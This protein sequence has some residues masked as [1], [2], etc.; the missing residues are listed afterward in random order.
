MLRT[1]C[2]RSDVER[3]TLD[4]DDLRDEFHLDIFEEVRLEGVSGTATLNA[5]Q[6]QEILDRMHERD[7]DGLAVSAL[8]R[9]FRMGDRYGN[10]E[11]LDPFQKN[12]KTIWSAREGV[13]EPWTD[14]GFD[15]CMNAAARS[16][17]ERR[18]IRRRTMNGKLKT[19]RRQQAMCGLCPPYG[20]RYDRRGPKNGAWIIHEEEA[21]IV[22]IIFRM[23][24]KGDSGYSIA[25]WLNAQGYKT[26]R[27]G[28]WAA[29]VVRKVLRKRAYIG[30]ARFRHNIE[31]M[32]R[33]RRNGVY[34]PVIECQVPCPA[35]LTKPEELAW[36]D[37]AQ[38]AL[39]RNLEK[40]GRPSVKNYLAQGRIYC[41]LCG[42]RVTGRR[43]RQCIYRCANIDQHTNKRKCPA[44]QVLADKFDE[45]LW[46]GILDRVGDPDEVEARIERFSAQQAKAVPLLRPTPAERLAKLERK[47][48][49]AER[50]LRDTELDDMWETAKKDKLQAQSEIAV[51]KREQ[52]A[53]KAVFH[54]P[55]RLSVEQF[56]TEVREARNWTEFKH[57]KGLVERIV[58]RVTYNGKTREWTAEIRLPYTAN[59]IKS[60]GQKWD[61]GVCANP[62][63]QSGHC[64]GCKART[65]RQ[66]P[67][68]LEHVLPNVGHL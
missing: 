47:L 50:I 26:N 62:Q 30:F 16:G 66:P 34:T 15:K 38:L 12:H 53:A 40:R 29:T 18:E 6:V 49:A 52:A 46:S 5:A 9:L 61:R 57:K 51:I 39:V 35:I 44:S 54:R 28:P 21:K 27:G 3:Q 37:K 64:G 43:S 67:E 41:G 59:A 56:C 7:V 4:L 22:R 10:M 25:D 31:E 63:R 2:D 17:S 65:L 8:D 23:A 33:D 42:E 19:L 55:P 14:E 36:F 1:S 45:S 24:A 20:Y 60:G 68:T 58:T 32:R 13:I 48:A 11:I